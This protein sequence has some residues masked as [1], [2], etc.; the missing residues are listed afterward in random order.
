MTNVEVAF[1]TP[2][3]QIIVRLSLEPDMSARQAVMLA[4][5]PT[6]HSAWAGFDF[7]TAPLGIFGERLRAPEDYSP[8]EGERIEVYRPL[9]IDPKQAR[10][11]RAASVTSR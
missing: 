7:A 3:H 2:E 9:E 8:L 10:R 4:D 1:A 11:E 5:L 6:R